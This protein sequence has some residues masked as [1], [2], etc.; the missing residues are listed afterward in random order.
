LK[1]QEALEWIAGVFEEPADR[2][3][4]DT[5]RPEILGW[6]SLGTLTLIAALDEQ[7]DVHLSQKDIDAMNGV[8][9]VLDLLRR[10]GKLEEG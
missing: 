8:R 2:I 7:F 10:N 1:T 3:S 4:A 9:D 6:D 5:M